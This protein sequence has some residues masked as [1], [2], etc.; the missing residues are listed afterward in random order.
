MSGK[1]KSKDGI[2]IH[3]GDVVSVITEDGRLL[4]GKVDTVAVSKEDT[5]QLREKGVD[6]GDPPKVVVTNKVKSNKTNRFPRAGY[7]P[8]TVSHEF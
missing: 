7:D 5:E 6:V 2:P 4:Q 8:E 1:L 3:R